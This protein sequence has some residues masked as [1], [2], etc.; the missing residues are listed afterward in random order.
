MPEAGGCS[1]GEALPHG[2]IHPGDFRRHASCKNLPGMKFANHIASVRALVL[3]GCLVLGR[4]V[5]ADV[6][7]GDWQDLDQVRAT[8]VQAA[9]AHYKDSGTRVEVAAAPLDQR[10]RLPACDRDL[11]SQVPDGSR[12]AS[13]VTVEVRCEGVR[14][15]R[16]YVP[17][18]VS[19]YRTVVVTAGPLE[20]G[21]VLAAG[22]VILAE[23]EIGRLP[24]SY[25]ASPDAAV[26]QLLRRSVPAGAVLIAA[27]LEPPVLVHR[28]QQVTL[29]AKSGPITVQMAGIA[30]HDAALGQVVAVQNSSSRRVLQGIVRNEKSVEVLVP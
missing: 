28:G 9:A 19:L 13:R 25:L 8:A 16:L 14:S 10:L 29:E 5:A 4:Q 26:G 2:C 11:A 17:V 6:R 7:P 15:W 12:E 24:G 20:R 30:R 23:R 27:Q 1:G 3:L 22:D 18:G 21:K